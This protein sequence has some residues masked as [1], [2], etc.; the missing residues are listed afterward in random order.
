MP[1]LL[2]NFL[3][4]YTDLPNDQLDAIC[5]PIINNFETLTT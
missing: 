3:S 2:S 5:P 4:K 1:S